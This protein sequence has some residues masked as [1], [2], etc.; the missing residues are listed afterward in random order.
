MLICSC[1]PLCRISRGFWRFIRSPHFYKVFVFFVYSFTGNVSL[2]CGYRKK[3]VSGS[4]GRSVLYVQERQL[5]CSFQNIGTLHHLGVLLRSVSSGIHTVHFTFSCFLWCHQIVLS[6][7]IMSPGSPS[8]EDDGQ[9]KAEQPTAGEDQ[10]HTQ[11]SA[12]KSHVLIQAE[13]LWRTLPSSETEAKLQIPVSI[14]QTGSC[15]FYFSS[16]RT[17]SSSSGERPEEEK[18]LWW[19]IWPVWLVWN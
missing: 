3:D 9:K 16:E 8:K 11:K 1:S 15:R 4:S 18:T 10:H 12:T 13:W 14:G 6:F 19:K 2:A 7:M 17:N 5:P